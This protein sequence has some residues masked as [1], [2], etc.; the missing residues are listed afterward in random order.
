MQ[1]FPR[2]KFTGDFKPLTLG[3]QDTPYV[4]PQ[5]SSRAAAI[6]DRHFQ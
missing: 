3:D 1:R 5:T 2:P 6:H 4:P